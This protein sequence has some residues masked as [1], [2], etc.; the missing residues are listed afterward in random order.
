MTALISRHLVQS[1]AMS[2]ISSNHSLNSA[3]ERNF[4]LLWSVQVWEYKNL[5]VHAIKVSPHFIFM[6]EDVT[7]INSIRNI[8]DKLH[9]HVPGC[10]KIMII[11]SIFKQRQEWVYRNG[12]YK[13]L[14]SLAVG[15]KIAGWAGYKLIFHSQ[16]FPLEPL[17]HQHLCPSSNPEEPAQKGF[18][19]TIC[20]TI[21]QWNS[22]SVPIMFTNSYTKPDT[23]IHKKYLM[24][25]RK[26]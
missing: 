6:L 4:S 26:F 13:N 3:A 2:R 16:S 15:H 21:C 25:N 1:Q 20:F 8:W 22:L 12:N 7:T 9:L 10:L 18:T 23:L 11:F 17:S 19:Y 5:I 14:L 24:R